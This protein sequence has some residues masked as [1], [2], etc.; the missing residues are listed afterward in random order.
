MPSLRVECHALGVARGRLGGQID[1]R[2]AAPVAA[3]TLPVAGTPTAP[4]DQFV[5]PAGPDPLFAELT[6]LEAPAYVAVGALPDPTRE[7][8]LLVAPG[9]P[10]R[11]HLAS[12][13]RVSVALAAVVAAAGVVIGR[14]AEAVSR[15]GAIAAGGAAQDLMGA[16]PARRGWEVQ[17]QSTG[18]L[19]IR[20]R[21]AAGA[22][23][24]TPDANSLLLE[25]G[26]FYCADHVTQNA[27]SIVGPTAGQAFYAREW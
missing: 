18:R 20:S 14:A 22:S 4:G 6:A 2:E 27:L 17:N 16:N 5:V 1:A 9:A 10:Q 25:P 23:A 3:T 11:V 26:D 21:G 13:D 24:A 12:G 15:S 8:R 7:P 19:W